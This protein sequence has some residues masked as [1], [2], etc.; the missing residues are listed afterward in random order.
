VRLRLLAIDQ[1]SVA[2][3]FAYFDEGDDV[4][5]RSTDVIKPKA[6]MPGLGRLPRRRGIRGRATQMTRDAAAYPSAYPRR[7]SPGGAVRHRMARIRAAGQTMAL[8]G[9]RYG[10]FRKP[11]VGGSSLPVGS[12]SPTANPHLARCGRA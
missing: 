2:C 3:G 8:T 4:R 7:Q 11:P 1:G 12:A 9:T 10:G 6:S 5:P